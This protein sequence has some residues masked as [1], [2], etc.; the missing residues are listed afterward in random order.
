MTTHPRPGRSTIGLSG[1]DALIASVPYLVGFAPARS[2]V[3][4]W[5]AGR[6]QEV[7][8]TARVDLPPEPMSADVVDAVVRSMLSPLPGLPADAR[9]FLL[10]F[11]DAP[12]DAS[13]PPAD[14]SGRWGGLPADGSGRWGGLP[15]HHLVEEGDRALR[16]AGRAPLDALCVVDDRWW[17]YLC[18]DP[19][20]CERCGGEVDPSARLEVAAMFVAAGRAPVSSREDLVAEVAAGP[21]AAVRRMRTLI[22]DTGYTPPR[23]R[24]SGLLPGPKLSVPLA[25]VCWSAMRRIVEQPDGGG[26]GPDD[27]ARLLVGLQDLRLRDAFVTLVMQQESEPATAALVRAVT[28]APARFIAPAA[29]SLAMIRYLHGDGARAWAAV[30]R[31]WGDDP[32][33]SLAGLVA[34]A[35][36]AGM[37]PH[38][39]REVWTSFDPEDLRHGRVGSGAA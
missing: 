13:G 31:C 21:S 5:C 16:A 39:F 26:A 37:P 15:A 38:G 12:A 20:D 23:R 14:G 11:P 8:L 19:S 1:P 7:A 18:D 17:S 24:R 9:P 29:G 10:T 33:Y 35:V 25:S 6:R 22:A 28:L 30:D 2:L 4:V 32:Q 36:A 3:V 34:S 27:L